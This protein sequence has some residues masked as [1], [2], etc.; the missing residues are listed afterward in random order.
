MKDIDK[1]KQEV[2]IQTSFFLPESLHAKFKAHCVMERVD[3]KDL[4]VSF[5]E[6]ELKEKGDGNPV[7]RLD[8]WNDNDNA[9]AVPAFFRSES[10]WSKYYQSIKSKEEYKKIDKQLNIILKIHDNKS[11]GLNDDDE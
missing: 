1:T 10:S 5:I 8:L 3:M 2:K 7:T 4:L 11:R 9:M 6:R